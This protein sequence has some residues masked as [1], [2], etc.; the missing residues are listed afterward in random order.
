VLSAEI[1]SGLVADPSGPVPPGPRL[2]GTRRQRSLFLPAIAILVGTLVV[3]AILILPAPGRVTY[4]FSVEIW[5]TVQ[6]ST[7][8]NFSPPLDSSVY[9]TWKSLGA[10][11]LT[12]VI[13]GPSKSLVYVGPWALGAGYDFLAGS[14]PYTLLGE[15]PPWGTN[16]GI[17]VTANVSYF[18]F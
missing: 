14:P 13:E 2:H 12:F 17:L 16:E 18:G 7:M 10:A 4:H 3:A 15:E 8:A 5:V 9:L 11:P 1:R 6:S